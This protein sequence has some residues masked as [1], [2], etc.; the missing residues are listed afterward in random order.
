MAFLPRLVAAQ[1][2]QRTRFGVAVETLAANPFNGRVQLQNLTLVNPVTFGPRE[3]VELRRFEVDVQVFSGLGRR[4]VI[5]ELTIDLPLLAIVT[6]T[7]GT[8]NLDLFRERLAG[9]EEKSARA[10]AR[11][12][13][14]LIKRLHVRVGEVRFIN[15][16]A[17]QPRERRMPLEFEYTFHNVSDWKQLL[18]PEFFRRAAASGGAFEGLLPEDL[19]PTLSRW[20]RAGGG[21]FHEPSRRATDT[22][23]SL[24]EKLEDST[25]P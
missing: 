25:K 1:L 23:K 18:V 16:T 13:E 14:F 15:L 19:G 6:N 7:D 22:L 21:L 9:E 4:W 24:F 10:A 11:E 3:F 20:M 5:D 12:R 8:T 17:R 2:A